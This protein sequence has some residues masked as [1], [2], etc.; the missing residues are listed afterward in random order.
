MPASVPRV[1]EAGATHNDPDALATLWPRAC[2]RLAMELPEQQYN[3][4]IRPLPAAEVSQADGTTM[5]AVRVPN[6]FMLDW[7]R[8]QYSA[9]LEAILTELQPGEVRMDIALAPRTAASVPAVGGMLRPGMAMPGRALPPNAQVQQGAQQGG[10]A[11]AAQALHSAPG[12]GL[13]PPAWR[14]SGPRWRRR[15]PLRSRPVA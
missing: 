14:A 9:R 15:G 7:I 3:T 2:E 13:T 6:R 12:Q 10:P 1:V 11:G 4:W 5:V 8:T